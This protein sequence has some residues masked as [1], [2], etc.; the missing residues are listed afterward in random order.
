VTQFQDVEVP[1]TGYS[2]PNLAGSSQAAGSNPSA[3]AGT[4]S[5]AERSPSCPAVRTLSRSKLSIPVLP[6]HVIAARFRHAGGM[7]TV[8]GPRPSANN[9]TGRPR[10]CS[11]PHTVGQLN[12]VETVVRVWLMRQLRF[13]NLDEAAL[14]VE[15]R[16]RIILPL[17][18]QHHPRAP[19]LPR[20]RSNSRIAVE[21][22]SRTLAHK[23]F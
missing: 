20:R 22:H 7:L 14:H 2:R 11:E 10:R 13:G 16:G 5:L 3:A 21:G 12:S 17:H 23:A 4:W 1:C 19:M 8:T 6:H 18:R 9:K 15:P